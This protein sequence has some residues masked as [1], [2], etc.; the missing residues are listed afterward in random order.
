VAAVIFAYLAGQRGWTWNDLTNP[1]QVRPVPPGVHA[2]LGEYDL[3]ANREQ[4]RRYVRLLLQAFGPGLARNA[5][6]RAPLPTEDD[7]SAYLKES[8]RIAARRYNVSLDRL[9]VRFTP[10]Q[11]GR[12]AGSIHRRPEGFFVDILERYKEQDLALTVIAAHEIAHYAM[13]QRGVEL[14]D[15][16]ENELLTDTL[17]VLAGYGPL[18]LQV[19]HSEYSVQTADVA[20]TTTI[21]M[22]YLHPVAVA[23][24]T[25][26][27]L[28]L[29]GLRPAE[30]LNVVD[31]WYA[32]AISMGSQRLPHSQ[33]CNICGNNLDT[34][35]AG[36]MWLTRC[37]L[38]HTVQR[39]TP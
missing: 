30:H 27:Q 39:V 13:A 9:H 10:R 1:K 16:Y 20:S 18:M 15:P 29:A 36:T 8:I 14:P 37:G 7:R 26:M 17:V 19:Y 38:C 5:P 4:L 21:G 23:Y 35:D 28:E 24:L 25:V 31:P 6:I 12:E 32:A 3:Q 22:G 2:R 33:A 34:P 11:L